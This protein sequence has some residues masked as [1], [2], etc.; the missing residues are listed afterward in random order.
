MYARMLISLLSKCESVVFV[1]VCV[2]CCCCCFICVIY[3]HLYV[4]VHA[5]CVHTKAG[6]GYCVLLC[7]SPYSSE[8]ESFTEPGGRTETSKL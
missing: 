7:F 6:T 3:V 5:L 8:R 4:L 1:C 2:C